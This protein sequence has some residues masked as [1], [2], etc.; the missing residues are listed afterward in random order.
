MRHAIKDDPPVDNSR[1]SMQPVRVCPN[2]LVDTPSAWLIRNPL[3]L[4]TNAP[5]INATPDRAEKLFQTL[6]SAISL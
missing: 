1:E 3:V 6:N 2:F 4:E 5:A